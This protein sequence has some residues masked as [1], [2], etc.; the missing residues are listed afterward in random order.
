VSDRRIYGDWGTTSLRLWL[1]EDGTVAE[2]RNGPGIGQPSDTPAETLRAAI[3]PW[4]AERSPSHIRL[5]GMVGARNGLH[6]VAYADCPVDVARW[7]RT[8]ADLTLDALP[9]RI[10]A[11]AACRDGHG[12]ADVMRGEETQ[13]FGAMRLRPELGS[14]RH[15]LVLP[16]THS[17]WVTLEDSCITGFRTFLTGEVFALLQGSSLLAA[18]REFDDGPAHDAFTIGIT[19]AAETGGVL[20]CLFE[21]RA[22]QLRDGRSARWAYE[23]MSGLLLGGELAEMAR[24][25]QL[26]HEVS[27]IGGAH[28]AERYARALAGSN[29]AA[30][31]LDGDACALA[32]LE[33]LDADD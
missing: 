25:G 26:P 30:T 11:G 6:E 15:V 20:G 8:A 4:I 3:A 24:M 13:V 5:C 21:A 2:C 27:V 18:G 17:K 12:R 23:F 31:P 9:L 19:R 14:G 28:L 1:V 33:L 32:G 7:R 22:A 10:A 29:I 16:G